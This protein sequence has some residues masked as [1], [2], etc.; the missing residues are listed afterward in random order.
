MKVHQSYDVPRDKM[1]RSMRRP[2]QG[3]NAEGEKIGEGRYYTDSIAS[4]F[5]HITEFAE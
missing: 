5:E 1:P 2:E 4:C 3:K